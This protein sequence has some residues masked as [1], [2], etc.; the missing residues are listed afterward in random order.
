MNTET[1]TQIDTR[2][3]P[4]RFGG[5]V[6]QIRRRLEGERPR[7]ASIAGA[8]FPARRARLGIVAGAFASPAIG[9]ARAA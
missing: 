6:G 9:Q 2:T 7:R 8:G 1:Q 5:V 3:Q 4:G